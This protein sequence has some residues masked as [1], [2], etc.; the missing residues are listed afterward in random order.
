MLENREKN[1][2]PFS[3]CIHTAHSIGDN[4]PAH[5]RVIQWTLITMNTTENR[6]YRCEKHTDEHVNERI[7][8]DTTFDVCL[9]DLFFSLFEMRNNPCDEGR[10][11]HLHSADERKNQSPPLQWNIE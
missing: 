11:Y 3:F 5:Q 10:E 7:Y 8:T 6:K 2:S 9:L 4:A 1:G